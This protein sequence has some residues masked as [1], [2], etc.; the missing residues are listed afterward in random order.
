MTL[1][2]LLSE[3][4]LVRDAERSA[5]AFDRLTHRLMENHGADIVS[6]FLGIRCEEAAVTAID[7]KLTA[8]PVSLTDK[9][10]LVTEP[11][12]P[13]TLVHWEFFMRP[14]EECA[15]TMFLYAGQ[16]ACLQSQTAYRDTDLEQVAVYLEQGP[17]EYA[18]N[19]YTMRR[20]GLHQTRHDFEVVKLWATPLPQLL[21]RFP[22]PFAVFGPFCAGNFESTVIPSHQ[23]IKALEGEL[24]QHRWSQLKLFWGL[25]AQRVVRSKDDMVKLTDFITKE[26]MEEFWVYRQGR[27]EGREETVYALLSGLL[28]RRFG[29]LPDWAQ[30]K[31]HQIKSPEEAQAIIERLASAPDLESLL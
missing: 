28:S 30:A 21:E 3:T 8:I 4:V 12:R 5:Q 27:E 31:L 26:E 1:L 24:D 2:E 11:K 10:F 9:L 18:R 23:A 14:R 16:I 25:S 22:G 19:S 17:E 29:H 15:S 6:A 20:R 7:T 13:A